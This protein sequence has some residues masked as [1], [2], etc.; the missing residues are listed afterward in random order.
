VIVP[1]RTGPALQV[2]GKR[3]LVTLEAG[4]LNPSDDA[5]RAAGRTAIDR[6]E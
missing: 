2:A 6:A 1:A 3:L 5:W 4:Y